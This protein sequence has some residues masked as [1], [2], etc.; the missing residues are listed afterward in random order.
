MRSEQQIAVYTFPNGFAQQA[1]SMYSWLLYERF[2]PEWDFGKDERGW[3]TMIIKLPAA[4]VPAL[5]ELQRVRPAR[6]GN[7]PEAA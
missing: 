2:N 7:C 3:R 6:W 4:E 5:R 1:E